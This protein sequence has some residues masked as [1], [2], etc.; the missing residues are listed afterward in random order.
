MSE[1]LSRNFAQAI[2]PSSFPI[3]IEAPSAESEHTGE[4]LEEHWDDGLGVRAGEGQPSRGRVPRAPAGSCP[5]GRLLPLRASRRPRLDL[6]RRQK[7]DR[8]ANH[9]VD[10]RH[11]PASRG[12][13]APGH[14]RR[15]AF[16][17]SRSRSRSSKPGLEVCGRVGEAGHH[18]IRR[19]GS[20]NVFCESARN[21]GGDRNPNAGQGNAARPAMAASAVPPRPPSP[22]PSDDHTA[23]TNFETSAPL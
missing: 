10:L 4:A 21:G 9:S 7:H 11:H 18:E 1:T 13:G 5:R 2:K 17:R 14:V 12:R 20:S 23:F 3:A 6:H 15:G 16:W 8:V 19:R 22:C